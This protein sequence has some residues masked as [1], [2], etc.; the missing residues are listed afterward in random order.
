MAMPTSEVNTPF[1]KL[2]ADLQKDDVFYITM[3]NER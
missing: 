3:R 2:D 1:T